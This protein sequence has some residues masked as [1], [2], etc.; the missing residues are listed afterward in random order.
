MKYFKN[1]NEKLKLEKAIPWILLLVI[2]IDISLT[3]EQIANMHNYGF[4]SRMLQPI[5]S[6]VFA[7]VL[8]LKSYTWFLTYNLIA[9]YFTLYTFAYGNKRNKIFVSLAW[10]SII[11]TYFSNMIIRDN[12]HFFWDYYSIFYFISFITALN[13]FEIFFKRNIDNIDKAFKYIKI[14]I[15][16]IGFIF[17]VSFLTETANL[18]YS[19]G[20]HSGWYASPNSIGHL[21][22]ITFPIILY[23]VYTYPKKILSWLSLLIS[24]ICQFV[25]LTKTPFFSIIISVIVFTMFLLYSIFFKKENRV[26][27]LAFLVLI[28]IIPFSMYITFFTRENFENRILLSR[29]RFF[30]AREKHL[31][32]A[33]TELFSSNENNN[34]VYSKLDPLIILHLLSQFTDT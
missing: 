11:L 4:F 34:E 22:A 7:I 15:I 1:I 2:V 25:I 29:D 33:S 10:L 27:N 20:G 21:L 18:T 9:G 24:I 3:Q 28:F 5:F 19:G 32:N 12:F 16:Y 14:P 31:I 17:L 26:K 13:G 30:S 8:P 6:V 23:C